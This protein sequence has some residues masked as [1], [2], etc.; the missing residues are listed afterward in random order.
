MNICRQNY[1]ENKKTKIATIKLANEPNL[2]ILKNSSWLE[3]LLS[4][5]VLVNSIATIKVN[6]I[7]AEK[8]LTA[9]VISP[10]LEAN[11]IEE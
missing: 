4:L 8:N 7:P 10:K 6:R 3:F 2:R 11:E 5:E 1:K 9:F